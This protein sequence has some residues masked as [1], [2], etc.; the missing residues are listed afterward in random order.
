MTQITV[1]VKNQRVYQSLH[2]VADRLPN[3]TKATLTKAWKIVKKEASGGYS[4]GASY[5]VPPIP[6]SLYRRTGTYGRSFRTSVDGTLKTGLRAK[7]VSNAVQKGR[8][9]T[10]YVGGMADGSKQAGIHKGRWP[11]IRDVVRDAI[12]QINRDLSNEI[13]TIIRDEGVGL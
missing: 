9:Y 10:K 4:G 12:K 8:A 1:T 6:G 2:R 5:A 7:M 13:K 11:V 3:L